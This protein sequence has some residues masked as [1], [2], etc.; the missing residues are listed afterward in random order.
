MPPEEEVVAGEEEVIV[1]EEEAEGSEEESEEGEEESTDG[2]EGLS[3]SEQKEAKNLYKMLK[4]K[5][6]NK[7]V[8]RVLAEQAGLFQNLETRKDVKEGVK[9]M[10]ELI[11][12]GL[13]PEYNGILGDRLAKVLE[14]VLETERQTQREHYAT[15]EDRQIAS[16][17]QTALTQL[18]SETKGVSK[19]F[20]GKM[21]ALMDSILP[22]AH[23]SKY[24]Y[25]KNLYTI[26][27]S[28]ATVARTAH[29]VADKIKKNSKDA[30]SRLQ[31]SAAGKGG[32]TPAGPATK[33]IKAA[34]EFALAQMEKGVKK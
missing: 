25:L 14:S 28:G 10:R 19:Q 26:A 4:D 34:A 31:S 32:G 29:A 12:D 30:A 20:E 5:S 13:G 9:T 11:A 2:D 23:L 16:D 27:S 8:L 33:G 6:T 17:T 1:G 3:E 21:I 18:R 22:A 15:L 7:Q 24:E